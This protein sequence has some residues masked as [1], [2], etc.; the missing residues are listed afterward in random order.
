MQRHLFSKTA[1][2]MACLLTALLL[3]SGCAGWLTANQGPQQDTLYRVTILHTNDHHGRFWN[4]R[5][6][7]YGMAARKTL[8]DRI[9]KEVAA[10]GGHVLLLDAGDINTGVPESDILDAEPDIRAMNRIGYDAMAAGNHEF[11]NLPEV[12]KKQMAWMLFPLLS[13]NVY[14][15]SSGWCLMQ[16][17]KIFTFDGLRIAVVGFTTSDTC[18]Q[19]NPDVVGLFKFEPVIEA[20]ARLVPEIRQQSDILVALTHIGYYPLGIHSPN[21]PGSV[22]LAR[23]VDGIDVIVDGHTHEQMDTPVKEGNAIIV[24]A[25]E[26]GKYLGRMDLEYRN[27]KLTLKNYRLIAVNLKKKVEK[28]EKSVRVLVEEEITADPEL[29]AFL[30]TYKDSGQEKLGIVIG[31]SDG[32]FIGER[33]IVR[34]RKTNLA[35]LVCMAY[36]EQTGADLAVINAGGI[37][38]SLPAGDITY[39]DV[40]ITKPFGNSLCTVTLTGK[41]VWKYLQAAV[42]MQPD[43][44]AF[45]QLA[46]VRLSLAGR[47]LVAV[48]VAGSA[49]APEKQYK[50]VLESYI[51]AGGDGYPTMAD[52]PGFVDTGYLDADAIKAY[53]KKHTPLKVADYAPNG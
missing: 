26:H 49:L 6:G 42:N 12:L 34:S 38:D 4:N 39:K 18:K 17:Y 30:K 25:F 13:A 36:M 31:R 10:E 48:E 29:L 15:R 27:G 35:N 3:L 47:R 5:Y 46:G 52:H 11:D 44:G 19:G 40:L 50:L 14:E 28:D 41:E 32:E 1:V 22:S 23:S 16:P 45:A 53:I 9:R 24:Q 7:E 2:W 51:A 21:A 8:V 37:R 33:K 20:A 43:T